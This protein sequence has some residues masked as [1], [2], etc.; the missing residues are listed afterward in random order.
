MPE[1]TVLIIVAAISVLGFVFAVPIQPAQDPCPFIPPGGGSCFI[2]FE[3]SLS[4]L[5]GVNGIGDY[6]EGK[7][8]FGC[9]PA[10]V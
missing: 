5:G 4:C 1:R 2:H 10:L 3:R 6:F 8:S 9:D 7:L